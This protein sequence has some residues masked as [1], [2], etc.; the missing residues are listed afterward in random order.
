MTGS[1]DELPEPPQLRFLRRLVTTLTLA[2]IL[3]VLVVTGLLVTRLSRSN[4]V[5]IPDRLTLPGGAKVQ[6][7]TQGRSWFAIVTED[8]RI[9][10]Y[11]RDTGALRQ[12][13]VIDQGAPD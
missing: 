2:M 4:D 3:G 1:S 9:L 6:A 13:V 10:I 11:D 12:T 8:D 5:A 7:F